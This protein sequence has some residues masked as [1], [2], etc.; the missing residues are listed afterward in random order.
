M[1]QAITHTPAFDATDQT[2]PWPARA[3]LA[4]LLTSTALLYL[5]DL[6]ESGFANDYYAAAAQAGASSWK[7]FFFGSLDA[8]NAITVDKTPLAVWPISLSVRLF[9]LSSFAVLMPQALEGVAT[10]AI[11]YATVRRTTSSAAA[12][13]LAGTVFALT[14]IA[15]LVFRYDNPDAML[16][17]LVVGAGAATLRAVEGR[18]AARWILLAGALVGLGFL[19]KMLEVALVVPALVTT[20]ALFARVPLRSRVLH[21]TLAGGTSLVAAGWW[22][23]LVQLWPASHRPWIGGSSSNNILEVVLGYNGVGR[24]TG[25]ETPGSTTAPGW[26][27]ADAGHLFT[28]D[29]AGAAMWL[30]P[31]AVLLGVGA[32]ML[33]RAC[34]ADLTARPALT[35]WLVWLATVFATFSLMTGIF[36]S[37]YVVLLS[38]AV[39]AL[40]AIGGHRG[41]S[42]RERSRPA[43]RLLFTA[44]GATSVVSF[45][46][47]AEVPGPLALLRWIAPIVL[48][49]AAS[50]VVRPS[51]A[52]P[53]SVVAWCVVVAALAAPLSYCVE[54]VAEPHTGSGPHAGPGQGNEAVVSAGIASIAAHVLGVQAAGTPHET[55]SGLVTSDVAGL[56][57]R[58]AGDYRWAAATG[59]APAAASLELASGAAVMA[60]GGYKGTDPT[61][62]LDSFITYVQH[63]NIHYFVAGGRSG[64]AYGAIAEW[65]EAR[66]SPMPSYDGPVY[67]LAVPPRG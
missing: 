55:G 14:P 51:P 42:A 17:L 46:L 32:L 13:L 28:L 11:L 33:T 29:I 8:G 67:D 18:R 10:V 56:L 52:S 24:I 37:Y 16:T 26:R 50:A 25:N 60:I 45:L 39:A 53:P 27:I 36:H 66:Y 65:V 9:G 61:P 23:L 40:V 44:A 47:L 30:M 5:W 12:G 49:V 48:V 1:R 22:V 4:V 15:A 35:L 34:P 57:D 20:Y 7:A 41:W 63:G 38:P 43:R 3:G 19:A 21:V 62:T 31:A 54:T 2:S 6:D 64:A 59:G 58:G